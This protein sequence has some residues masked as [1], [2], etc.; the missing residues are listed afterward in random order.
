MTPSEFAKTI[1]SKHPGAYDDMPDQAL[2]SA[3]LKKYPQYKDMLDPM[4]SETTEEGPGGTYPSDL[5]TTF[6]PNADIVQAG[7]AVA[8]IARGVAAGLKAA[9]EVAE[10]IAS[11]VKSA[12]PN[13][14]L[15]G[16]GYSAAQ[17]GTE[18]GQNLAKAAQEY[19]TTSQPDLG[20]LVAKAGQPAAEDTQSLV[21]RAANDEMREPINANA[22]S[23]SAIFNEPI[24]QGMSRSTEQMRDITTEQWKQAGNAISNTLKGLDQTGEKFD[25]QP[26][27]QKINSMFL[28][29][30]EGNVMET[31]VQGETNAA[32]KDAVAS[33]NDYSKGQPIS[34]TDANKIKSMLQDS[35]NYAAKRF[36]E[37]NEA[38]KQAASLIKEGIDEQAGGVLAKN[39]GDVS[40]FQALRDAYSKL[41]SLK[42]AL[43]AQTGKEMLQPSYPEKVWSGFKSALP[44]G[45]GLGAGAA[46]VHKVIGG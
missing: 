45:L 38:Y 26:I 46:A 29:D 10:D 27:L 9:P 16:L 31:G 36:E 37:S 25:P 22:P 11:G 35:A 41:S 6:S 34:F 20:E 23:N 39:G 1:R 12:L 14:S 3:I 7:M 19:A 44:W 32:L 8:P 4:F 17:T 42:G 24:A 40:N 28:K 33:L 5:Y 18:S 2:T 30:A 43:N 21:S 15:K 13:P